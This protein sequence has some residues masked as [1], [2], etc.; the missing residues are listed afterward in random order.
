MSLINSYD[1]DEQIDVSLRRLLK[2]SKKYFLPPEDLTLDEW[3][4][5]KRVLSPETSAEPGKW[6]T[7]R[8][9]YLRE[10]MRAVN[11]PN[12]RNIVVVASSQVGKTEFELNAIGYIIDQGLGSIMYA[13]PT[14]V[15]ARDFST[16]RIATMIR[17]CK[18]LKEK[19][20]SNKKNKTNNTI[21]TKFYPG[22]RLKIVGTESPQALA[23]TPARFVIGD[24]RDRWA[25]SSGKEGDPWELLKA[26]QITFYNAK[27]IEVSTPTVKGSSPIERSFIKGT[28][29]RWCHKCPECGEYANIVWDHIRFEPH[30][31]IINH[32]KFYSVSN[33]GFACPHCGCI[34]DEKTMKSQPAKW[35]AENPDAYKR[36]IRS[37]WLNAFSSPWAKW[38]DIIIKFLEAKDNPEA[39]QAVFN[40]QLGELWEDRGDL[41]SED[42]MLARREKYEADLPEG[43]LALTCGVDTQDDRLEYEVVGY[44][45]FKE[46]W[47][48]QKGYILGR[49]D[50]P[51]TWRG[52]DEVI[53]R[54]YYFKDGKALKIGLTFVDSGGHFTQDVYE[55]CR[56]RQP[57]R[58]F[59]IKG[60][61]GQD[62][63][64]ISQKPSKVV[65]NGDTNRHAWLYIIGVDAG[66]TVI[67]SNL[68][69]E[70][71]GASYC[72]FPSNEE[73]GYDHY[74]F[75][76]LI[77]E[78]LT[79]NKTKSGNKWIWEKIPGHPRNEAL[80]CR[81]YA[82]AAIR[83]WNPDFNMIYQKLK[84]PKKVKKAV[85]NPIS[86]PKRHRDVSDLNTDW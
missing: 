2:P 78:K 55:Q 35:I 24:E 68:R 1:T 38:E 6:N 73:R 37:F 61:G 81:N 26:R 11:D 50:N 51:E 52:L 27:S 49:P 44:G 59:A 84:T 21:L 18:S 56:I 25:I 47:G 54:R 31:E 9:P 41:Q 39:L 14:L 8:T 74:Y 72:H 30:V 48:I 82:N 64:Y 83:V 16:F 23:G 70:S 19:V 60:K 53:D 32:Q 62:I 20:R 69:V 36:G 5:K 67:M 10:P 57:K 65:V 13:L 15:D 77:S 7:D 17:D 75:N 63:P 76:C 3:A 34:S 40:T 4:D 33:V 42:E 12:V 86:K 79:L 66:K 28:Q 22:G 71:H 29:E 85:T 46:T 80:D 45:F 43:V 58:V